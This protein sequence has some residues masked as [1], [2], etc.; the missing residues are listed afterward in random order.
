MHR[1]LLKSSW[2]SWG[3]NVNSLLLF[4][5][6]VLFTNHCYETQHFSPAFFLLEWVFSLCQNFNCAEYHQQIHV[7]PRDP[8]PCLCQRQSLA[9]RQATRSPT[10]HSS[11]DTNPLQPL[12]T[13]SSNST[14]NPELSSLSW[15][16]FAVKFT[17]LRGVTEDS[18]K[19][20]WTGTFSLLTHPQPLCLHQRKTCGPPP[21]GYWAKNVN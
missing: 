17:P 9:L 8:R 12:P 20:P 7:S 19:P 10:V 1:K 4:Y 13:C 6:C 5:S 15:T 21:S 2:P 16:Q 14:T 11:M 3:R 18:Q